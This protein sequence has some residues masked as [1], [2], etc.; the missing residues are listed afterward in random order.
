MGRKE[1]I[2]AQKSL[3]PLSSLVLSR[4]WNDLTEG[5]KGRGWRKPEEEVIV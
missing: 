2:A 3:Q 5:G 1:V 4:W